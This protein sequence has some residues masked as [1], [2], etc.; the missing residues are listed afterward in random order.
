MNNSFETE[1]FEPELTF[2]ETIND[3]KDNHLKS[4]SSAATN[5]SAIKF[6]EENFDPLCIKNIFE[7]EKFEPEPT[8]E[9]TI[10][11]IKAN[12]S[13]SITSIDMNV[14]PITYNKPSLSSEHLKSNLM[15][16]ILLQSPEKSPQ[17][18]NRL[19]SIYPYGKT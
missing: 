14:S 16:W 13:K 1:K 11:E 3:I 4:I 17:S 7:V 19:S 6:F 18:T 8:F 12:H 2:E 9:N 10:N 5:P 15:P